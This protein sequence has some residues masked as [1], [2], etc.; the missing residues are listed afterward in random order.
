[1]AVKLAFTVMDTQSETVYPFGDLHGPVTM[2]SDFA[3]SNCS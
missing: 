2:V 1:M 3:V